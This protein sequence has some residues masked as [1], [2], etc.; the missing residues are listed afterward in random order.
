VVLAAGP[1][2][3]MVRSRS[4]YY[5]DVRKQVNL[6]DT[7]RLSRLGLVRRFIGRALLCP[8]GR[9]YMKQQISSGDVSSIWD[10]RLVG[11]REDSFALAF[12][13]RSVIRLRL[14]KVNMRP[15][16]GQ[17]RGIM[18]EFRWHR[19]VCCFHVTIQEFSCD[20]DQDGALISHGRMTSAVGFRMFCLMLMMVQ[21]RRSVVSSMFVV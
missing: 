10:D 3:A 6:P 1:E 8:S 19:N 17:L 14:T 15:Q 4:L 5:F 18:A 21:G 12:T 20:I 16:V 2:D 11:L 13:R 7:S 9:E